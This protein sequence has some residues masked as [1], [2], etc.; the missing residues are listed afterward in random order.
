LGAQGAI[1][2]SN[3]DQLRRALDENDRDGPADGVKIVYGTIGRA[4]SKLSPELL[5]DAI[6]WAREK[7]K[8][9][10]VHVETPEEIAEAVDAGAA[11]LEHVAS[12]GE[13]SAALIEKIATKRVFV[14]PTF[15]EFNTVLQLSKT[16]EADRSALLAKSYAT[17]QKLKQAGARFALGTDSPLVPF[18]EGFLDEIDYFRKAGFT[19]TEILT[20]A[21]IHNAEYLGQQGRLGCLDV[22]CSADLLIL[23]QN[24]LVDVRALRASGRRIMREGVLPAAKP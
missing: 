5:R 6:R 10:I 4:S 18:G 13:F 3:S 1:L 17:A 9:S 8:I 22:G 23:P 12:A 15:G 7:N 16:R 2:A 20:I 21:T 14:D 24:P 11:G 19:H